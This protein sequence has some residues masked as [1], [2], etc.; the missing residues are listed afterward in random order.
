MQAAIP[1]V[2]GVPQ[3]DDAILTCVAREAFSVAAP[4][5]VIVHAAMVVVGALLMV[6][7]RTLVD[8]E[9]DAHCMH[10]F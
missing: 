5:S 7:W 4:V 6:R 8:M 1:C 3:P 10:C 2:D 9:G